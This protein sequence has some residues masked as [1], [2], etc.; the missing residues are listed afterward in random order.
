MLEPSHKNII[1][2]NRET[3]KRLLLTGKIED[4]IDYSHKRSVSK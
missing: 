2:D 4:K 3:F 1:N